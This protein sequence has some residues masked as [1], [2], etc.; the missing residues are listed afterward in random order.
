MVFLGLLVPSKKAQENTPK[1]KNGKAN[2][3][4][5][6]SLNKTAFYTIVV[7]SVFN[8]FNGETRSVAHQVE[9]LE[10]AGH[11]V[12]VKPG[13]VDQLRNVHVPLNKRVH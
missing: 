10:D 5:P 9:V 1:P 8:G 11:V 12:H 13:E 2:H 6:C 7:V 3:Y 4:P